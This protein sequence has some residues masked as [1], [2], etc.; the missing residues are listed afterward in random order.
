MANDYFQ[1]RQ[2]NIKQ[3]RCAMKV[4]TDAC[5]FGAW[6]QLPYGQPRVLDVGCGT[7]LL[8]LMLAQRHPDAIIEG[9]ELDTEAAMQARENLDASP[10]TGR[11]RAVAGDARI[12]ATDLRFN[13]LITNPPFFINSLT[14]PDP[15]R[16]DARHDPTL[17]QQDILE[18]ADRVL[19]PDGHLA[20]ILPTAEWG[21][22]Q[23]LAEA[24]GW[25]AL[26]ILCVVPLPGKPA[27]RVC[28]QL[29][30]AS[31][32]QAHTQELPIYAAPGVY[33]AEFI[34]LMREYYLYL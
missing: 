1:F 31:E 24:R 22:F 5:I 3:G 12:L 15:R 9:I 21:V 20:I 16:T 17:N 8:M 6:T 29:T 23:K 10:W 30:R 34:T 4:T 32:A 2:F 14:N 33:T 18:L 7:G 13:A 27:N 19:T 28:A 11:L 26:R 25:R